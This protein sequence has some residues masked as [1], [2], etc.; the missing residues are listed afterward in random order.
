VGARPAGPPPGATADGA[1][2][3]RGRTGALLVAA[4]AV[5]G[6][7]GVP[8]ARG[9]FSSAT[10]NLANNAGAAGSFTPMTITVD[11]TKVGANPRQ[12]TL[13]LRG[14]VNVGIDWGGATDNCPTTL[15][16]ANQTTDTACTYTADGTYTIKL[17]GTLAQF[18]TGG[19]ASYTPANAPRIT[20][21]TAWGGLGLQSLA[22]AF[23]GAE[24]LTT[25][26][27][28]LPATVTTLAWTFKD[29]TAFNSPNVV[30]W[31]TAAVT[32]LTGT[33]YNATTFNQPL[34][35]WTTTA[36]TTLNRTF[37]AATAFNQ[38]LAGWTTTA[39]TDLALTF[40]GATAFDQDLST[41][42]TAA[43]TT[44]TQT[45]NAAATFNRNLSGWCVTQIPSA[46]AGFDTDA[47][48]WT[49]TNWRPTWGTCPTTPAQTTAVTAT[50]GNAQIAVSWTAPS[51]G[52]AVIT[53]YDIR[54]STAADMTGA[55]TITDATTGSVTGNTYNPAGTAY[56]L[57]GLTGGTTYYLQV[58]ASNAKGTATAWGPTTPIAATAFTVPGAPTNVAAAAANGT[59]DVSWD[60]PTSDGGTAVTAYTAT[61]TPGGA[62]CTVATPT[63][64]TR[65]AVGAIT[66]RTETDNGAWNTRG[67]G[68]YGYV[69][70]AYEPSWYDRAVLP[71]G[72][73]YT[74]SGGAG[75]YY[76]WPAGTTD[77]RALQD[78]AS[79]VR[80]ARVWY[81]AGSMT[82]TFTFAEAAARTM[83][84]YLVDWDNTDRRQT[85]AVT[86][87]GVTQTATLSSSF[88][89]GI[90][91]DVPIN[92]AAGGTVTITT[93]L[94]AG[95]NAVLSGVFF[96]PPTT[97]TC[98]IT[99][100]TA[101][102]RYTA[103][104]VAT[105]AAGSGTAGTSNGGWSPAT[106]SPT[107]WFDANDAATLT[108][109]SNLVSAWAD[110]SGNA[111][112]LTQATAGNRPAYTTASQNGRPGVNFSSNKGLSASG[113]T[114]FTNAFTIAVVKSPT[115][116]WGGYHAILDKGATGTRIGGLTE[117]ANTG[118]HWNP[119]PAALWQN[120]TSA[121]VSTSGF[122]N[123]TNANLL[124]FRPS[125]TAMTSLA[126]GNYDALGIGG[127]A[128]QY[129]TIALG[130]APSVAT[131]QTIE[132]YLAWKWGT[133]GSL[134]AGHPYLTAPPGPA[135]ITTPGA[136]TIT[137]AT[138]GAGQVAVTWTPPAATGGSPITRYYVRTF[139][140]AAL[141]TQVGDPVWTTAAGTTTA[142][143]TGL[144]PQ[145]TYW[146]TVTAVSSAGTGT[147]SASAT[148]TPYVVPGAPTAVTSTAAGVVSWTAPASNGGSAITGSTATATAS[149]QTTRTCTTTVT[150]CV[151]VGLVNGVTYSVTVTATNAA[152]TGAASTAVSVTPNGFVAAASGF[153]ASTFGQSGTFADLNG[154][155]FPDL[156]STATLAWAANN[157]TGT[158]TNRGAS[159]LSSSHSQASAM[160]DY[161]GD[162]DLDV[163][164]S[165]C[166]AT[167]NDKLFRN[168]GTGTF[169][170][171][172]TAAGLK[173][174]DHTGRRGA[175][176]DFDNDGD[177]D[178][179]AGGDYGTNANWLYRNNGDGTFTDVTTASGMSSSGGEVLW[180]DIDND[181]DLDLLAGGT[182]WRN[183]GTGTFT[184]AQTGF[185]TTFAASAAVAGDYDND[186]DLDLLAGTA[187]W[188]NN[189]TGTF[190]DTT[191]AAGLTGLTSAA[192]AAFADIDNDAD[193]DLY[194]AYNG[195]NTLWRN[196]GN[197]TFT[198]ATTTSGLGDPAHTTDVSFA[199]I[200]NDG[201]V[202]LYVTNYTTPSTLYRN[203]NTA[204]AATTVHRVVLRRN[205]RQLTTGTL[206]LYAGATRIATRALDEPHG[207]AAGATPVIFANLSASTSYS[208]RY[209][210]P[211]GT[212]VTTSIGAPDN[213]L[214]TI[215]AP[216]PPDAPTALTATAGDTQ[217]A[218][219]WTAPAY[220]GGATVTGYTATATASGQTTRT[221]TATAPATSCTVTGLVNGVTYSVSVTATNA[222]G[223]GT[224][225]TAATATPN[226]APG[227]PSGLQ[228]SNT[229]LSVL[230]GSGTAGS[231]DG[232][233][234][235]ASFNSARGMTFDS[236][237]NLYVADSNNNKIRKITPAGVVTTFAGSGTAGSTDATGTAATF[238]APFDLA[239]DSAGNLYVA[240]SNNNKIRKITPA[241]VVTTFAGSGTTG[242][243][244][245]TG[246]AASFSRP[247]ALAFDTA[248]NLYVADYN[249]HK[250][251]TIT[252]AGVVTTFAGSG[253]AG[254]TDATGAAASFN[255]PIG[256]AVDSAGNLYV[257]DLNNQKIRTITPA[258]VVT[259]FAGSGTAGSTDATGTAASFNS[260][261]GLAFDT[262]GNL[263][264][265]DRDNHKIRRIT[266]AGVVTTY[267]GNGT[268][269]TATGVPTGA[270]MNAPRAVATDPAGNLHILELG[271][272]R[273]TKIVS[274][275]PGSLT[276]AWTAPA[277]N[278]GS[279][280]TD[281]AIEY[282]TSPS[283]TWTTFADGTSTATT[284]TI[285]GLAGATAYDVRVSAV[286]AAGTG[287]A[288]ATATATAPR[289][290]T[291][292]DLASAATWWLDATTSVATSGTAVTSWT[293][294]AG[295]GVL[296]VPTGNTA[297]ALATNS[298]NGLATVRFTNDILSGP[299]LLGG[300]STNFNAVAVMR[301]NTASGNFFLNLNGADL[302]GRFSI[303]A[304]WTDRNW[305]FDAGDW[306]TNSVL[307]SGAPTAVGATTL[308]TMW[309]DQTAANNGLRLNGGTH[310]ATSP[311]FAAA[312]TTG[313]LRIGTNTVDHDL[314]E[315]LAFNRRLTTTEQ[316]L[317]EG[318]LAWRWGTQ[319]LL[320]AGHPHKNAAPL[321]S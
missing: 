276:L 28:D 310:S 281:Y 26:P 127:A 126:M 286:N 136:P 318:Y 150:S 278:G 78:P 166:C 288:S 270:T 159:G 298:I 157:G 247:I 96:D 147:A 301:E 236:T 75:G 134:P 206:D 186:G 221:C 115:T 149:G 12:V 29:A 196:N 239:I 280:I 216:C 18:G 264:V 271:G 121:T 161:D 256:L 125:T 228:A 61:L 132:G 45:F 104:V 267:A 40:R 3:R 238:D 90:W 317:V 116:T 142:T 211:G 222:A 46:P 13:P 254:S 68:R 1:R 7:A 4:A 195:A 245:A 163:F 198:N 8:L 263:Y 103:S 234:T 289:A 312:T 291:P 37:Y 14:N 311:G 48:A 308:A 153:L 92:V 44:M 30:T 21:V 244:D 305:Y 321:T 24:N 89:G 275:G 64:T 174:T 33:F 230:A 146:F 212:T 124:A 187:L 225:S 299:D 156:I 137:S 218:L 319:S 57:T 259:T 154:D 176:A 207:K 268:A 193:I 50:P 303:H 284:A 60:P 171:V 248:G 63:A 210:C 313:G 252:P 217:A 202:D 237:G 183:N 180:F 194:L 213:T 164:I 73:S 100:L 51:N 269:G 20:G 279:A 243:T 71:A 34:A 56:T 295:T 167:P 314:A 31:N 93:T 258:G 240:D 84:L 113:L 88:N 111:R 203:D 135:P 189:G 242:S 235:A 274:S 53:G 47:T 85:V 62:Q 49:A 76:L 188:A 208:I 155:T 80:N 191:T 162:G 241:G 72:I 309:K 79:S 130:T 128:I 10:A 54:W 266:A 316:N 109:S 273:I 265:A 292:A 251:R 42:N 144:T 36:V 41:W 249:N 229:T 175:W 17:Y 22:G 83:R 200:D 165:G 65:P 199:D 110:K 182:V 32:D 262:A 246:T 287:T 224:A 99:G 169:T 179:F 148:A 290:W 178:L 181:G 294:R 255:G 133:Q 220:N 214:R 131:R 192:A 67:H 226:V 209:R 201:D 66:T 315:Y 101:G 23:N 105:N 277:S 122:T 38:P 160:G 59:V 205:N 107:V 129:E 185:P 253:T 300:T 43:V 74:N 250:I 35:G 184:A 58:R 173:T 293:S 19:S 302:S 87:G 86:V 307:V 158:F 145:T 223:T 9:A 257:A 52:G 94:T 98:T 91:L 272:Q 16:A 11:T 39:V 117:S 172:T 95:T 123:I 70:A 151:L 219:S 168:D 215:D 152:G 118:M 204:P 2:G 190:T 140:D 82:H 102:T 296:T 69:L 139:S 283:G 120:G 227:A 106:V 97:N 232:N 81:T 77:T 260:P 197:G 170:D 261:G 119:A 320:P 282:R 141:T 15:V 297:P 304:P 112:T 138:A 55:T 114:S 233:G 177:P 5:A 108:T 27:A 6:L 306:S 231:T 285:T 25:V 143:V